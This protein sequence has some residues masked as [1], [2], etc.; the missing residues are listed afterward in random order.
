[1]L[2]ARRAYFVQLTAAMEITAF[3]RFGPSIPAIAIASTR[4]GKEIII[5]AIRMITPSTIP[6]KYPAITP[7]N[8]PITKITATRHNVMTREVLVPKITRDSKSRPSLSVP[9][10]C[11]E[12]GA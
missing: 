11:A 12:L 6:P 4:P 9:N 2:R 1:M 8:V 3:T 7:R 5:S 10:G